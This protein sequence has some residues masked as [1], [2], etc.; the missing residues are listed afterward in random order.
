MIGVTESVAIC[1]IVFFAATVRSTIGFGAALISM[2]LLSFVIPVQ[3]A[4]PFVALVMLLNSVGVLVRERRHIS[5]RA[6]LPLVLPAIVSVP[7]GVWLLRTGNERIVKGVLAVVVITFS[8]WSLRREHRQLL[9]ND[10]WAPL[11]GFVAGFLGGAY[12]VSGP[13]IV[14]YGALR[15]WYPEQFRG[16]LQS[17]FIVSGVW[18]VTVHFYHGLITRDV[19]VC[20]T[21][22]MPSIF[23]GWIAGTLLARRIPVERFRIIVQVLL[24]TLSVLLLW[25]VIRMQ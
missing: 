2:P 9:S 7:L 12:N 14:M 20:F 5:L 19:L 11:A 3:T 24:L 21:M 23:L 10:R 17:F 22:S 8:V 6:V 16:M 13:P 25:N 15:H 4:A 18:I 1:V